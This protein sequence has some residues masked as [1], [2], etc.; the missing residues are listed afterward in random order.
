MTALFAEHPFYGLN[1]DKKFDR[2]SLIIA[3]A[4]NFDGR[5][6]PTIVVKSTSA[7]EFRLAMDKFIEEVRGH[8]RVQAMLPHIIA[9]VEDDPT[10]AGT[11][12]DT[13]VKLEFV[14]SLKPNKRQI[15]LRT[16]TQAASGA[17]VVAYFD[18][19]APKQWRTDII[20]GAKIFFNSFND[21]ELGKAIYIDTFATKQYLGDLYGTGYDCT[22]A[23]DV[24][25]GS[26][27][28][29]EELIDMLTAFFIFFMPQRLNWGH[30]IVTKTASNT[31][32]IEKDGKVGEEFFTASFEIDMF[33]EHHF[34]IPL[35]SVSSYELWVELRERIDFPY[36]GDDGW[37]V[38]I[39]VGGKVGVIYPGNT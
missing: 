5:H 34:F 21:F 13:V 32:V 7:N 28:E 37:T 17:P 36:T 6:F 4:F 3:D 12:T 24:Y 33:M 15:V 14:N 26:Q 39:P 18:D 19:V 2:E 8:V 38:E 25:A 16:T 22:V 30:G 10:Y 31:R 11:Y 27:Y 1:A 23:L 9:K 20:P 35:A 29:A